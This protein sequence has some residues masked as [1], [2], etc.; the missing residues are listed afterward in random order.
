[1]SEMT[2]A[3]AAPPVD[4]RKLFEAELPYV[5]TTLRRLGVQPRDVADL[6]QEVF[7]TVHGLLDDY[8]ASR[9]PRPWLFAIAYRIARRHGAL[10]RHARE[11]AGDDRDVADAAPLADARMES[12]ERKV[13]V[14]RALDQID[15]PRRSVLILCDLDGQSVP[16]AATALGIPLNT[17]YSRLRR[18]REELTVSL[19]KLRARSSV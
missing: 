6:A 13:A 8:D 18:A 10:V 12:E 7:V 11:I 16:D 14:R 17:A 19:Q 1:M 4:F 2:E 5:L 3:A 15:L 9:P